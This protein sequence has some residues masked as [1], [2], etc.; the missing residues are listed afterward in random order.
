MGRPEYVSKALLGPG[1]VLALVC[2][3]CAVHAKDDRATALGRALIEP[4][5]IKLTRCYF[6]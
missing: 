3:H 1:G 6:A 5:S 2:S 4:Q